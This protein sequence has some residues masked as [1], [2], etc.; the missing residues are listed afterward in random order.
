MFNFYLLVIFKHQQQTRPQKQWTYEMA[1]KKK[2]FDF[3]PLA[4]FLM[5]TILFGGNVF[6]YIFKTIR[7]F[8]S[9]RETAADD[10][11][12]IVVEILLFCFLCSKFPQH[13]RTP[14]LTWDY[15]HWCVLLCVYVWFNS[16]CSS[17]RNDTLNLLRFATV[18]IVKIYNLY[19]F[20]SM[21]N[22]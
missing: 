8:I 4:A 13:I 9:F 3:F 7:I 2:L 12:G 22:S 5:K 10:Y 6:L 1:E 14:A 18:K 16:R 21:S 15:L 19:I 20:I 11:G 17:C